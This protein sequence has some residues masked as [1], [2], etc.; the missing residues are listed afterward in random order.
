MTKKQHQRI[1]L[2]SASAKVLLPFAGAL[3]AHC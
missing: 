3:L 2:P 1:M